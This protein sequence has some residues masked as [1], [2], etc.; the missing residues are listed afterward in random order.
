MQWTS[1]EECVK[2]KAANSVGVIKGIS[3]EDASKIVDKVFSK[4][5]R[6]LEPIGRVA[7]DRIDTCR[8]FTEYKHFN[9]KLQPRNN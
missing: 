2:R 3:H 7:T 8:A 1:H 6:D 5:Y 9:K 4:C